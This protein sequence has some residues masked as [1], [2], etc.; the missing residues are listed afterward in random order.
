MKKL[1][2]IC[3]VIVSLT[4][5]SAFVHA[6]NKN[7]PREVVE[8]WERCYGTADMD[9]C[10]AITTAK[11][12]DNKPISVWVYDLWTK[13]HRIG[14]RKKKSELL[15]EKIDGTSAI[16]VLQAR[17]DALDGFVDQKEMYKL[18]K[19]DDQWLIDDLIIG[20]EI[21]EEEL[22]ELEEL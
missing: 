1:K 9:R 14:Y 4:C 11:M 10:G 20:D 5:V 17:I 7:T 13:L 18:I 21:L 16:I 12:R 2:R 3:I 22:E 15:K 19:I 6:E 8:R